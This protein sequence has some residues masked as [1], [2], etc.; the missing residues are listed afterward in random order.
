MD[1]LRALWGAKGA[2]CGA[3]SQKGWDGFGSYLSRLVA[4][5]GTIDDRIAKSASVLR[6]GSEDGSSRTSVA[7]VREI[8]RECDSVEGNFTFETDL[9]TI[10]AEKAAAQFKQDIHRVTR[11]I[12]NENYI[13][14]DPESPKLD[15]EGYDKALAEITKGLDPTV[16]EKLPAFLT[17]TLQGWAQAK[18]KERSDFE[19]AVLNQDS[20]LV[21]RVTREETTGRV[22]VTGAYASKLYSSADAIESDDYKYGTITTTTVFPEGGPV[23]TVTTKVEFAFR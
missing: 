6:E 5:N 16:R 2:D 4:V 22:I 21:L 12:G 7:T 1:T 3:A 11:Y 19:E 20:G 14:T 9:D 13:N 18:I 23:S 8:A 10:D 15:V 17:Q